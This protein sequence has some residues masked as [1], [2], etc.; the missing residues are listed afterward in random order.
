MNVQFAHIRAR[1]LSSLRPAL[2]EAGM[3]LAFDWTRADFSRMT[4]RPPSE[5][6]VAVTDVVHCAMIDVAEEGT[7]AVAATLKSFHIGG[8]PPSFVVDR[9]F[10]FFVL[11]ETTGAILFHGKIVEPRA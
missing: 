11:D 8:V 10:L 6:P 1:T 5:I 7:E 4:G 9:P 3:A 2:E